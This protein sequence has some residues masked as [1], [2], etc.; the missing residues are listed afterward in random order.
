MIE[1]NLGAVEL[2]STRDEIKRSRRQVA[3][4]ESRLTTSERL[5]AALEESRRRLG[6]L[7]VW[8]GRRR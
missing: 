5:R 8:C 6:A 4:L 3:D 7:A 2:P 1:I